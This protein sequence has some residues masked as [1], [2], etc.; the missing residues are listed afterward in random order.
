MAGISPEHALQVQINKWVRECVIVPHFFA[1]IDRSKKSAA[2]THVREKARG[3]VSGTPDT[4]LLIPNM[5]S[6]WCEL[7]APGKDP[8]ATQRAIGVAISQAGHIWRWADSVEAY[9]SMLMA[10][11]EV[12]LSFDAKRRAEHADALLAAAAIRREEAKTGKVSPRRYAKPE[13]KP[14]A[15]RLKKARKLQSQGLL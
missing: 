8:T 5:P 2:F 7:K 1:S 12:P 6:F 11:L 14:T 3:M 4:V 9:R 15:G 13:P 10:C